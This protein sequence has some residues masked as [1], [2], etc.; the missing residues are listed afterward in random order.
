MWGRVRRPA[1]LWTIVTLLWVKLRCIKIGKNP[2]SIKTSS[3]VSRFFFL[4]PLQIKVPRNAQQ[5]G[6]DRGST[7]EPIERDH[8][9]QK[10]FVGQ[11]ICTALVSGEAQVIA[12]MAPACWLKSLATEF[13]PTA[14]PGMALAS[15]W[16]ALYHRYPTFKKVAVG[17][18][19]N[20]FGKRI[21]EKYGGSSVVIRLT[22]TSMRCYS[23]RFQIRKGAIDK[24]M[25]QQPQSFQAAIQKN[26]SLQYLLSLPT[27]YQNSDK[28]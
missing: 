16:S 10:S 3:E 6:L 19:L 8:R 23:P 25:K 13:A 18:P 4:N 28:K 24:I 12:R 1:F 9:S 15:S 5:P 17:H 22:V 11:L 20:Y 27:D 2:G 21:M 7:A 26:V 14:A